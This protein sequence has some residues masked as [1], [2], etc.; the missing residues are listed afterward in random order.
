MYSVS[1][2]KVF[3]SRY[4]VVDELRNYDWDLDT[5]VQNLGGNTSAATPGQQNS[6]TPSSAIVGRKNN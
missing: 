4:L 1:R 5:F 2:K 6:D 3:V